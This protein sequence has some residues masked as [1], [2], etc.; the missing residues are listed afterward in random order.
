M[1]ILHTIAAICVI[2]YVADHFV[3][4]IHAGY[5]AKKIEREMR[6]IELRETLRDLGLYSPPPSSP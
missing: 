1:K 6:S 2:L 3:R 5:Q 4:E